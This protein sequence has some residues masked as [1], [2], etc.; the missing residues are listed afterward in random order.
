MFDLQAMINEH[1]KRVK[2]IT[3][4]NSIEVIK[5]LQNMSS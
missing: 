3:Q 2:K 4:N 1:H 5:T